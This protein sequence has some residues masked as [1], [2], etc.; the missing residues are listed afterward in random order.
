MNTSPQSESST[1]N[2]GNSIG[3][4]GELIFLSGTYSCKTI[5][6]LLREADIVFDRAEETLLDSR[7][8]QREAFDLLARM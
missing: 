2:L 6:A 5:D 8:K 3:A 7:S 1:R 4:S